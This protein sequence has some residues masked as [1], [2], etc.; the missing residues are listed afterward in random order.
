MKKGRKAMQILKIENGVGLFNT[1]DDEVWKPIDQIEKDDLM[2]ILNLFVENEVEI[3]PISD[4]NL[5]NPAH[6]L[7]YESIFDKL[8]TLKDNKSKFKDESEKRYYEE[9]EKYSSL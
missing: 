5:Q 3:D 8:Q 4:G 6:K 2:A 7:I 9:I 1:S